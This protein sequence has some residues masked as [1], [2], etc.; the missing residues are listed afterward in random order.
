MNVS[1]M[2]IVNQIN[3]VVK[4]RL[5]EIHVWKLE[6]VAA[7]H[8]AE[9]STDVP[10]VHAHQAIMETQSMNANKVSCIIHTFAKICIVG[11]YTIILELF[12]KKEV[13]S[14]CIY[15]T[16]RLTSCSIVRVNK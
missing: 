13:T 10:S 9:W 7:M 12:R 14:L 1:N 16:L 6:H 15:V 4:T 3:I 11:N 2:M 8:N 5:A